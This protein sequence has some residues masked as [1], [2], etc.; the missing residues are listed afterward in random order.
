[1]SVYVLLHASEVYVSL[2][3]MKQDFVSIKVSLHP[4]TLKF[5]STVAQASRKK[6]LMQKKCL[7][8]RPLYGNITVLHI[9][10]HICSYCMCLCST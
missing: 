1:M 4:N 5:T 9:S 3:Y 7:I 6:Y 2:D 8:Q 10:H